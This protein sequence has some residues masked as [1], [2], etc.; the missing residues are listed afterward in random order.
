ME[1]ELTN[2]VVALRRIVFDAGCALLCHADADATRRCAARYNR[3]GGR[4][5]QLAPA[6]AFIYAPLPEDA[7]SGCV[8]I[9]ARDLAAFVQNTLTPCR[10][11]RIVA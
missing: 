8:R 6:V 3:V 10:I 11:P 5:C 7:S 1:Q 4:L 2:L 9:A